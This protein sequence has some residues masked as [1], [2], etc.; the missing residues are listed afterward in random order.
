MYIA[1]KLKKMTQETV[2]D[3]VSGS[4]SFS[5]GNIYGAT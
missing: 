1:Y 3:Y 2:Q 4:R 5:Q